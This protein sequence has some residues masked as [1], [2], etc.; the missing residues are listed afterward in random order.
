M[1]HYPQLKPLYEQ[2]LEILETKITAGDFHVGDR[3]PTENELSSIYR[4]SR[5]VIREAI[6]VLKEK[7]LV[8]TRVAKG[9]FVVA[10]VSKGIGS[11][12]DDAVKLNPNGGFKHL[13]EV[14]LILEPEMA[15]L[16]A[17]RASDGDIAKMQQAIVEM[18]EAIQKNDVNDYLKSDYAF[19]MAMA[20]T[21]GNPLISIIIAPVVNLMRDQQYYHLSHVVDGNKRSQHNHIRI[22]EGISQHDSIAARNAM[23]QHILQVQSDME[24]R[25]ALSDDQPGNPR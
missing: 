22:M 17:I 6:K 9:T 15:H 21:T 4:V 8:E 12:F 10:S 16:A 5:T 18:D 20:E 25:L 14:R 1:N 3:L 7:G 13:I 24:E 2:V 19:H 23:Y 11:S